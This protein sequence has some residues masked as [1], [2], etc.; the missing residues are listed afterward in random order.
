MTQIPPPGAGILVPQGQAYRRPTKAERERYARNEIVLMTAQLAQQVFSVL[1]P[2]RLREAID[3]EGEDWKG[4]ESTGL[5]HLANE[6]MAKAIEAAI[7]AVHVLHDEE[8]AM[9]KA[10]TD[11]AAGVV[12]QRIQ[13]GL[14]DDYES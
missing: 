8:P 1:L 6:T 12:K 11:I 5:V 10:A 2:F 3:N 7:A 14:V 4:N 13:M 9:I